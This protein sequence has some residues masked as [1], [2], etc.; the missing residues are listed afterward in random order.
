MV[1]RKRS[2]NE[3]EKGLDQVTSHRVQ[4]LHVPF[5]EEVVS[6]NATEEATVDVG[7]NDEDTPQRAATNEDRKQC[8]KWSTNTQKS[9]RRLRR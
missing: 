3:T 1:R 9:G 4:D 2:P 7:S 8:F 6:D 5:K